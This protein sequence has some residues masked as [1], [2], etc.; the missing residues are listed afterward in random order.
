MSDDRIHLRNILRGIHYVE[1]HVRIRNARGNEAAE[2]AQ[3]CYERA[4]AFEFIMI[5]EAATNVSAVIKASYS[6]IPWK[7]MIGMRN[8][9]AHKPW[10]VDFDRIDNTVS[11]HLPL[12]AKNI[13]TILQ[14]LQE[15]NHG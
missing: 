2:D 4:V 10:D 11:N 12:L 8:R 13:Q 3:F 7:L 9:L 5:G 6:F 14:T 15:P 1:S